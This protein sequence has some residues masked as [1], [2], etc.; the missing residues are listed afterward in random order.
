MS[1][2]YQLQQKGPRHLHQ[3]L[4]AAHDLVY[5]LFTSIPTKKFCATEIASISIFWQRVEFLWNETFVHIFFY[6]HKFCAQII[7]KYFPFFRVNNFFFSKRSSFF[8]LQRILNHLDYLKQHNPLQHIHDPQE[9]S[10]SYRNKRAACT[11][12]NFNISAALEAPPEDLLKSRT[13]NSLPNSTTTSTLPETPSM[14]QISF[15]K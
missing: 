12:S 14:P 2:H 4:L 7:F 10:P 13:I 5:S 3:L 1:F 6:H 15:S 11:D 8:C 9:F